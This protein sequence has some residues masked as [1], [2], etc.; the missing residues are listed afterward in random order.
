MQAQSAPKRTASVQPRRTMQRVQLDRRTRP[1]PRSQTQ[2]TKSAPTWRKERRTI[3]PDAVGEHLA[4]P[5]YDTTVL[6]DVATY[7]T[8]RC[9]WDAKPLPDG[10]GAAEFSGVICATFDPANPENVVLDC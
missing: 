1:P 9:Q 3:T 5:D 4:P 2:R 10:N 7:D 6:C 8:L